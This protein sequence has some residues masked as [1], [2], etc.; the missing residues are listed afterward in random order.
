MLS[1]GIK[2]SF[3]S[4]H[5]VVGQ[6]YVRRS[7][8]LSMQGYQFGE[9]PYSKSNVSSKPLHRRYKSVGSSEVHED[10]SP[11]LYYD[12]DLGY[13]PLW[14]QLPAACKIESVA[15]QQEFLEVVFADQVRCRYPLEWL[16]DICRCQNCFNHITHNKRTPLVPYP[17][18]ARDIEISQ[19]GDA[20]LLRWQDGHESSYASKILLFQ[21]LHSVNTRGND[22]V[23]DA[24]LVHWDANISEDRFRRQTFQVE[25]KE[26][27]SHV[28]YSSGPLPLHTDTAFYMVPV[29]VQILHCIKQSSSGGENIVA[30]AFRSAEIIRSEDPDCFKLL[31]E[32]EFEYFDLGEDYIGKHHAQ[33]RHPVIRQDTRGR[34]KQIVYADHSRACRLDSELEVSS[35][36]F[37]ALRKFNNTLNS[38]D[39]IVKYRLNDG[40]IL[41]VD[42]YRVPHGRMDVDSRS[43]RHLEGAYLDWD[44]I[45]SRLRVLGNKFI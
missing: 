31:T 21:Y 41:V 20:I 30:D 33:S 5:R 27:A 42:N 22:I 6:H 28:A 16:R 23:I 24:E 8:A 40:E 14:N 15:L 32:T 11:S 13:L 45:S 43:A 17:P 39:S 25:V 10:I 9:L 34:V 18:K 19:N 3:A 37:G 12:K 38:E 36:V 29:G 7:F 35:K 4:L 26:N 1:L 44:E 2:Q